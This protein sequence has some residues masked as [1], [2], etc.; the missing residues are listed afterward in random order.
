MDEGS[1]DDDGHGNAEEKRQPHVPLVY[2]R[3]IREA[4]VVWVLSKEHTVLKY[5]HPHLITSFSGTGL[6]PVQR[7]HSHGR[8]GTMHHIQQR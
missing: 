2:E 1:S 5:W 7:G 6:F 3:V 4:M 8:S